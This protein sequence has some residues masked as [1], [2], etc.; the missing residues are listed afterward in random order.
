MQHSCNRVTQSEFLGVI[1]LCLLTKPAAVAFSSSCWSC[2]DSCSL[3]KSYHEVLSASSALTVATY[4]C[5]GKEIEKACQGIFP[6]QNTAIRK[7][8][9]LRAPKL[10]ITKLMEVRL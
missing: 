9:V 10:D 3:S 5:A 8:K 4:L 7:V 1:A 2:S 6:L